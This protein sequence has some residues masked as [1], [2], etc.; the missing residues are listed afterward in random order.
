MSTKPYVEYEG[1]KV[2]PYI[3]GKPANGI[4]LSFATLALLGAGSAITYAAFAGGDDF[5]QGVAAAPPAVTT[6]VVAPSDTQT[7]T[8]TMPSDSA[9]A[10]AATTTNASTEQDAVPVTSSPS[11]QAPVEPAV[12]DGDMPHGDGMQVSNQGDYTIVWGDTLSALSQRFGVGVNALA[13]ANGITNPHLIFA[14]D[15]MIIANPATPYTQ[16]T[17]YYTEAGDSW[18]SIA[19]TSG[20]DVAALQAANGHV[21]NIVPGL[22][23]Q[24]PR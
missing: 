14:G 10:P 6:T 5:S 17:L 24:I 11:S 15:T 22:T 8:Q 1:R 18:E 21:I 2:A 3:S 4:L 13:A 20:V 19:A 7:D 16:L 12:G 9:T 23:L